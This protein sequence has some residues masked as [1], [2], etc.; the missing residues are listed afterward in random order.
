M[1]YDPVLKRMIRDHTESSAF[2]QY[3]HRGIQTL[4]QF[5]EFPVDLDPEGLKRLCCRV[6]LAVSSD[7]RGDYLCKF[8]PGIYALFASCREDRTD[9]PCCPELFSVFL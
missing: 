2:F 8:C 4:C 6:G 7:R 5:L 1:F 9:Y 3:P